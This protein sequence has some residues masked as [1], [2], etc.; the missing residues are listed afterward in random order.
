MY[1][2]VD[3]FPNFQQNDNFSNTFFSVCV[4]VL[5][6]QLATEKKKLFCSAHLLGKLL[7]KYLAVIDIMTHQQ[8]CF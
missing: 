7:L 3:D 1:D 5:L 8:N 2:T 6:M 4:R